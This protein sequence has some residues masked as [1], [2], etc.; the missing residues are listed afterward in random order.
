MMLNPSIFNWQTLTNVCILTAIILIYSYVH[1][2]KNKRKKDKK[3][4]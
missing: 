2:K 4:P 1:K 3:N